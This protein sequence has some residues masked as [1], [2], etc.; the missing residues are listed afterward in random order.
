MP[1]PNARIIHFVGIGGI[2]MSAI[3][4]IMIH[5]GY[6]VSG[7]DLRDNEETQRLASLGATIRRGHRTENVGPDVGTVVLSSAVASRC[8]R[9]SAGGF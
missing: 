7:S 1:S 8:S 3:A 4:N 9:P 5:L 2:G 6:V